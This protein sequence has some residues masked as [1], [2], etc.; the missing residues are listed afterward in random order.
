MK[1]I[2]LQKG[3]TLIEMIVS[4]GIFT[5]VALIAVGALLKISDANRKAITLKTA[6][7]NLNFALESMSREMRLGSNYD[8]RPNPS[9]LNADGNGN[10]NNLSCSHS[11][12]W[13]LAFDSTKIGTDVTATNKCVLRYAYWYTDSTIKKA[14]EIN[15]D[16]GRITRESEYSNV[17]S[18][19]IKITNSNIIVDSSGQPRVSFYIKGEVGK[20]EKEK[21]GFSLQT[22]VSQR[23]AK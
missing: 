11:S 7:N 20:R 9:S 21:T 17:L 1:S 23:D 15:C 2:N 10:G 5:V 3:F 22:T 13:A 4:L 16:D 6:I 12:Q 18:P 14:Q 8:C 19:D